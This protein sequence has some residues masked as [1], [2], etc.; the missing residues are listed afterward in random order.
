MAKESKAVKPA[1]RTEPAASEAL[2]ET[3][4][5]KESKA[6]KTP[7]EKRNQNPKR[8]KRKTESFSDS[9]SSCDA[10]QL[11]ITPDKNLTPASGKISAIFSATVMWSGIGQRGAVKIIAMPIYGGRQITLFL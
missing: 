2:D 7:K 1:T 11:V 6:D 8:R 4:E 9:R 10:C 5:K 3:K